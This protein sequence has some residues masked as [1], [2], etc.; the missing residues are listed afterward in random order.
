MSNRAWRLMLIVANS[1]GLV[2]LLVFLLLIFQGPVQAQQYLTPVYP[3]TRAQ[4]YSMPQYRV[5]GDRVYQV[6]PGTR[7][8]DYS[9]REFRIDNDSLYEVHPGTRAQDFYGSEYLW[10]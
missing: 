7:A 2:M 10:D 5:Q 9:G 6:H 8:Q 4:D 1:A 3:G